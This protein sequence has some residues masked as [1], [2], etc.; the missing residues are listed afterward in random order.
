[1]LNHRP[2]TDRLKPKQFEPGGGR[3]TSRQ[4]LPKPVKRNNH[5]PTSTAAAHQPFG[6]VGVSVRAAVQA[7]AGLPI[8]GL[9][10]LGLPVPG[11][12]IPGLPIHCV[13]DLFCD[14][15]THQAS[16]AACQSCHDWS[17]LLAHIQAS[18]LQRVRWLP[19]GGLDT[20]PAIW[21]ALAKSPQQ[22]LGCS[23][24]T[25]RFCKTPASWSATLEQVYPHVLPVSYQASSP[26][27][28]WFFKSGWPAD[29]QPWFWQ[30]ACD[31]Q[32]GSA[33]F[34]ATADR[35]QWVGGSRLHVTADHRYLGNVADSAWPPP[36]DRAAL[37]SI[38]YC[39]HQATDLRGLFGIDYVR[40]PHVWP[41]EINPRPTASVEVLAEH[42][43]RNL[44]WEHLGACE[45]WESQSPL[46][47][48][49]GMRPQGPGCAVVAKRIL[50]NGTA[51]L[52]ITPAGFERLRASQAYRSVPEWLETWSSPPD[53]S[54]R[55]VVAPGDLALQIR[56][57]DIPWPQSIIPPR[58]PICT[59]LARVT[60]DQVLSSSCADSA[61]AT[62][63]L[64]EQLEM[65][66]L[67]TLRS[68]RSAS[69]E[70]P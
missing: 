24:D 19:I 40:N 70:L 49:D 55:A 41:L 50:Y 27:G 37:E 38:A 21:A 28:R 64:L 16:P 12:P 45:A 61:T 18:E 48:A 31:G 47:T 5:P 54:H 15:D 57:A 34:L 13:L 60:A 33:L 42:L 29:P 20:Q 36:V 35:V 39:L 46:T 8:P 10:I 26:P 32:L 51:P 65:L 14:Y 17:Q 53:A 4:M 66:V 62:W 11:L 23:L 43:G 9:P 52:L 67:A 44:Y 58:E 3:P 63:R 59:L 68:P 7:L 56:V 1:M 6:L 2:T 69:D 22:L 30:Q 25:V